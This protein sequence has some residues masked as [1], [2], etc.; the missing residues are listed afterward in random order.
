MVGSPRRIGQTRSSRAGQISAMAP[1][2]QSGK[3]SRWC[4][5][6]WPSIDG[7]RSPDRTSLVQPELTGSPRCETAGLAT[8]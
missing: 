4:R 7:E 6:E 5:I 8:P 3:F 1:L 2:A